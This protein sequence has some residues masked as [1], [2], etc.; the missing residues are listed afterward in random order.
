ME[1]FKQKHAQ[2]NRKLEVDNFQ[3]P[4]VGWSVHAQEKAKISQCVRQNK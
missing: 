4:T 1:S 2:N 3:H